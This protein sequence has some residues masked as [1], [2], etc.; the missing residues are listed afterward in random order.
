MFTLTE[1]LEA[2]KNKPEFSAKDKGSYTVIDYNLNTK[3]TFLGDTDFNTKILLNLRGTAFDNDSG[4]IIRLGYHKFF[5]YGEFPEIDK[6][7]N[8]TYDHVITKKLDGSCIFPMYTNEGIFLGTRAGVTDVSK[9]ADKYLEDSGNK[10]KYF[11]FI[12]YCQVL[13]ITPIFEY[14]SRENRVVLDYPEPMLVLTGLRCIDTGMYISRKSTEVI[15]EKF[16]IPLVESYS[17][18]DKDLVEYVEEISKLENDEGVVIRYSDGGYMLKIKATDYVLKHRALDQ[19]RFEKDVILL[20][21]N[22]LMDDVY[23]ILDT[24]IKN[25]IEAYLGVFSRCYKQTLTNI[26]YEFKKFE[27]LASDRKEFALAIKDNRYKQFLFKLCTDINFD[28]P[29]MLTDY[30]KKQ[31][32]TQ[33]S[34]KELKLFLNFHEVYWIK[35]LITGYEEVELSEYELWEILFT[36]LRQ[37]NLATELH[38]SS[39]ILCD[40]VEKS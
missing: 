40:I 5:N 10:D 37:F 4:E 1:A 15:S 24:T 11:G 38:E 13:D 2:I 16:G 30:C 3:D 31:C 19:L 39:K 8:F 17:F 23:P 34:S 27:H 12:T 6:V 28:V 33:A 21:L 20:H 26:L 9:L 32:S 36:L 25:K 14:C 7:L 29:S 35:R 22:G 18:L